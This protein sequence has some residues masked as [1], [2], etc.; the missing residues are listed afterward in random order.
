M[1]RPSLRLLLFLWPFLPDLRVTVLSR[2]PQG[3][4]GRE[5]QRAVLKRLVA[6]PMTGAIPYEAGRSAADWLAEATWAKRVGAPEHAASCLS[7]ALAASP[8][9]RREAILEDLIL[10]A[11]EAGVDDQLAERI[12]DWRA[13]GPAKTPVQIAGFA[14][15]VMEA[16]AARDAVGQLID[17]SAGPAELPADRLVWARLR[18]LDPPRLEEIADGRVKVGR[19]IGADAEAVRIL[20][21][22]GDEGDYART[23]VVYDWWPKEEIE[24]LIPR[25]RAWRNESARS[26]GLSVAAETLMYRHG[27]FAEACRLLEE[28][29]ALH[30]GRGAIEEL[31]K[32]QVRLTMAQLADGQLDGAERT[33]S[34]ARETVNRLGPDYLIYEHAG[35]KSGGDLYPEISM[36]SNFAWYRD[37]DWLAVAEHW[38]R[39]VAMHESGGSPV[40]IVEAAMAAQA[41][42]RLGRFDDACV[43]LDELASILP[44]LE[45]RDWAFNGAVGR[46]SHAIWD[47]LDASYAPQFRAHAS[48]LL[49]AGVGDWT[50]TSLLQT[51]ARMAALTGDFDAASDHFARARESFSP[52]QRPQRAIVDFDE[53]IALRLMDRDPE[54]RRSL[55]DAAVTTFRAYRMDGWEARLAAETRR[56]G[57]GR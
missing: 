34:R 48:D 7:Q 33:R 57:A 35:T 19:W 24:A 6:G 36:E 47:M 56:S 43:Y 29:V 32:A 22:L 16:G 8:A 3:A 39:A 28:Q 49:A 54:R 45:P 2:L 53:A 52:S 12:A 42:A 25:I 40:H 55:L 51:V 30:Q 37:G 13:L 10:V 31:A 41:Y 21:T 27:A 11:A 38:A 1:D 5:D 14:R 50:N 44:H 20:R 9:G 4:S 15:A 17:G 18:M 46:A 26:R 23:L